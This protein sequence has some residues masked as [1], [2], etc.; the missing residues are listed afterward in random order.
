MKTLAFAL[1]LSGV[2]LVA[3]AQCA[4]APLTIL[5]AGVGWCLPQ[6]TT[7]PSNAIQVFITVTSAQ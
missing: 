7:L 6:P 5:P 1:L 2:S 4:Q 3:F